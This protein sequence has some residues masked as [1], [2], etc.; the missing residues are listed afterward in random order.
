[1]PRKSKAGAQSTIGSNP[2][3]N[4][5][6]NRRVVL[7]VVRQLGPVGRME[8][9]RHA[10]LSTQAVSNIVEELVEDGLLIK[11]GRL[12]AGRGLPPIQFAVNPN[13]GMTAGIEIAADHVSTLL[14]DIGGRVRAQRTL[15]IQR[16]DP[17]AVLPVIR[18]EIELAQAQLKP[19][20]PQLLGVGVVM[21]GPFNV[22]GMTSVGPTTLSGWLDFDA[23]AGIGRILDAPITL[24]NDATAA[25]VGERLHGAAKDLK[26][27]CLI[28]FGQG[29]GLGI[30]IDGRPYR[31]ANGNAGEIGHVLVEKGGRRCSCGQHGCLEAYASIHALTERLAAAGIHGV[32]YPG[33]EQLHRDRHPVVEA[34]IKEAAAY[35]APQIAMLENLFDP[36]AIVIGGALPPGLL[37]NLTQAMQPLPLSVARRR[38]R[39]E[40]RLIHGRTGR[41]TA[42]LGAAALPLLDAMTPRLDT[43]QA[44]QRE[45]PN[46]EITFAG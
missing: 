8:I 45:Q 13:G 12:R 41:L 9:S 34:W 4:R 20:V 25:A 40:A 42:A 6:H 39:S 24:E 14:V 37:E 36:E 31:G 7:D 28:F 1:M 29:L 16:N 32:D 17:G 2:E 18:A 11:A 30:M 26:N 5:S 21:P 10:H 15:P 44:A 38:N 23:V 33:L 19:P 3:R 27:F 35:L 46:E 43:A 22:E